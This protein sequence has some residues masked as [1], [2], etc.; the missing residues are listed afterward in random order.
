MLLPRSNKT[1]IV[2]K[3]GHS[4]KIYS[5]SIL[6]PGVRSGLEFFFLV[7]VNTTV[8]RMQFFVWNGQRELSSECLTR[9]E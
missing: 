6:P 7:F 1:K 2:Y 5:G 9:V 3:D 4:V 8:I